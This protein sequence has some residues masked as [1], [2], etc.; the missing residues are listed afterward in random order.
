MEIIGEDDEDTEEKP[1]VNK[2]TAKQ[3]RKKTNHVKPLPKKV[4][5]GQPQDPL[6]ETVDFVRPEHI[7]GEVDQ[8]VSVDTFGIPK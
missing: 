7:F 8:I 4:D 3:T 5:N 1:N 6:Q 2:L